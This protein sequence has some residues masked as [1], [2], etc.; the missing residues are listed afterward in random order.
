VESKAADGFGKSFPDV[1]T[2]IPGMEKI[3]PIVAFERILAPSPPRHQPSSQRV[4]VSPL[5]STVLY[6]ID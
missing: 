1:V 2:P 4:Q 5:L 6:F 3:P